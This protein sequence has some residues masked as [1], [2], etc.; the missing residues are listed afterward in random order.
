MMIGRGLMCAWLAAITLFSSPIVSAETWPSKPIRL[1]VP[2]APGGGTDILA[3]LI[4]PKL[5]TAL[6]T[7]IVVENKPGAAS[8]TGTQMVARATPDGYTLVMVDSTFM[9][10]PGLRND[11][12]YDSLKDLAP[13]IHLATGPVILVAHPSLAA[14][15]VRELIAQ[16][17]AHPGALFYGS[18]GNGASTHLAG[19]L[20]NL[21]AGTDI[22]HV[23]Y[24]G[25]G[26][27][28][29]AVLANQVPL[30]FT[31]IS[32]AR[33]GVEAG[34]LKALAV[35]GSARNS[36]LPNVPTFD[37]AGLRG[38]D[39]ST[40][41]QLL[42]T[43]GT[44]QAVVM[45]LNTEINKILFDPE[46]QKRVV[47]LGYITAGGTPDELGT[48]INAEVKKWTKVIQAAHISIQ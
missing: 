25:T 13:V 7:Q 27:A 38:V 17:K 18:G 16:A 30:T 2:F 41:W 26:E 8:I 40:H 43:A 21:A 37:E 36:A 22:T 46:V 35:T 4:V 5:S 23:P 20:F 15:T 11:L 31:G 10:N 48:L 42:T 32:S 33:P 12:P 28:L 1:I 45:R 9:I 44:P 19:A 47:G 14:N 3:R 39:S 34:K 24:K 6:G 29:G